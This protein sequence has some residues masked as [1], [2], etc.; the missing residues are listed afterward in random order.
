MH[1]YDHGLL[2]TRANEPGSRCP[3]GDDH[4]YFTEKRSRRTIG[5]NRDIK[6]D[7]EKNKKKTLNFH[8]ACRIV[9][10]TY[11]RDS[12]ERRKG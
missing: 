12:R 5:S 11:V 8:R 6:S 7:E 3:V 1:I 4:Q 9:D 2:S 10:D